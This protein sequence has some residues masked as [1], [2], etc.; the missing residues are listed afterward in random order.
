MDHFF[1]IL[2]Q[3]RRDIGSSSIVDETLITREPKRGEIAQS[4][5]HIIFKIFSLPLNN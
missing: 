1:H 2:Y 4:S 3:F 5:G